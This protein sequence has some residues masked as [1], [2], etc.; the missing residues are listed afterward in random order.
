MKTFSNTIDDVLFANDEWQIIEKYRELDNHGKEVL[1]FT[2][3]KE[4]ERSTAP[5]DN[6]VSISRHIEVNAVNDR[7]TTDEQKNNADKVMI[8]V[9]EWK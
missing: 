4:W 8:D 2:L 6:I 9:S 5:K 1:D 3:E 7:I